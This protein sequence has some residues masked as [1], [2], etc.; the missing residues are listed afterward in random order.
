MFMKFRAFIGIDINLPKILKFRQ[1]IEKINADI[2]LVEIE[3]IHLTL[4]FLGNIEES[5]V[6]DI[7]KIMKDC[8]LEFSPFPLKIKGVGAFP[9][10]KFM[11]VVWIGIENAENIA[12][13]AKNLDNKL[14][15]L[16]FKKE[17]KGFSPHITIARVKGI[18]N[19]NELKNLLEK[20]ENKE[21]GEVVVNSICLKKSVLS[22]KGPNYYLVKKVS[23]ENSLSE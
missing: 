10:L 17:K 21:F 15:A 13:I 4:K 22:S 2:K 8:V 14:T 12:K 23:F 16:K 18:R 11:R 7:E 19:K 20:N 5:L 6:E 1:E 3:N 9:N